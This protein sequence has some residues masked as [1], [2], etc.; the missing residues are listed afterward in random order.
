MPSKGRARKGSGG[1]GKARPSPRNWRVDRGGKSMS[2]RLVTRD[3]LEAIDI[4]NK[5]ARVAEAV[6]HHPDFH[7]EGWNRL[8]I[9]T[10]SHDVGHLTARDDRLARRINDALAGRK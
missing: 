4:I 9:T 1:A 3:F 10:Y 6:K 8:R 5:I 7:L 2:L